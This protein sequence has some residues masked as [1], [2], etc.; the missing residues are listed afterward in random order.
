MTSDEVHC[1]LSLR[2]VT[3]YKNNLAFY[4]R[5]ASFQKDSGA[6]VFH[7]RVPQDR[8]ALAIDTLS[9]HGPGASSASIR[10]GSERSSAEDSVAVGKFQYGGLGPFLTSCTGAEVELTLKGNVCHCGRIVMVEKEM[11]PIDGDKIAEIQEVFSKIFLLDDGGKLH[12]YELQLILAV[13]MV[14]EPL[15]MKLRNALLSSLQK[16]EPAKQRDTRAVVDIVA[17]PSSTPTAGAR[18]ENGLR[19]SYID[20]CEEWMCSY[21]LEIEKADDE[22][23]VVVDNHVS[24]SSNGL[25]SSDAPEPDDRAQ[26]HVLGR[27]KNTTDEDWDGVKLCLVANE[28][29]MLEA[30]GAGKSAA[31][32]AIAEAVKVNQSHG[33]QVFIKTLTGKTITLDVEASD[34]ISCVKEKIQDKEGIPP[35]QQRLIFAGKQLEDCRSLADYNIQKESTLHL[36][37]RLRGGPEEAR[38]SEKASKHDRLTQSRGGDDDENFE[39]LDAL[40]CAGLTEIVVYHLEGTVS[41]RAH[42]SAVVTLASR[43]LKAHRVIVYE[44]KSNEVNA[45]KSIH[46]V[47]DSDLVL[48]PGSI[49]V[50]EGGRFVGQAQFTPMVPGDDQLIPYG[51]D[52]T[53]SVTR[54]C[55]QR[56]QEAEVV[57]VRVEH[58]HG[59]F[60][61][62]QKR[63][64]TIYTVKNNS[65]RSVPKFY[66]DHTASA[67]NGGYVIVTKER[68]VKAVTGFSRFEFQLLPQ[69][70]IEFKVVEESEFDE[71]L[72]E[73]SIR[74]FLMGRGKALR[75]TGIMNE[76]TERLLQDSV[77]LGVKRRFFTHFE[78]P[79]NITD[80]DF[81]E[82]S[83]FGFEM[84][85]DLLHAVKQLLSTREQRHEVQRKISQ[86]QARERKV[87]ENQERLRKNIMSMEK[88]QSCGPLLSRYL[89]DLNK[90]EDDLQRTRQQI[91][92]HQEENASLE[93][94][95]KKLELNISSNAKKMREELDAV[96]K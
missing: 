4:E 7:L 50:L 46:L 59:A 71:A 64:V 76:E 63:N 3:L 79:I 83:T 61:T 35:D 85:E 15:R 57:A 54:K 31:A 22:G 75:A 32:K 18:H 87:F 78:N 89:E 86:A 42:D 9:L 73:T 62:L 36:V 96:S 38:S 8:K 37:L 11:K 55:P 56:L 72:Q 13:Q 65:P 14:D 67:A 33:M 94:E 25:G 48:A 39:S 74:E 26:L 43:S 49:G 45:I 47:N 60:L 27:I 1:E 24:A 77:Q 88:V 17:Q 68:A 5:E 19:V 92:R 29:T 58:K 30:K 80:R 66:I 23:M 34:D 69:A 51:Q 2:Q 95:S 28:L 52:T 93:V 84:P 40:Q 41:V 81:Q 44:F 90:D 12:S 10:I 53:I 91:E 16:H 20:R 21:R 6:H 70:E 82:M